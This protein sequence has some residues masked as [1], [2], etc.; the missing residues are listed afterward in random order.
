MAE[1]TAVKRAEEPAKQVQF[2]SLFEQLDD[3]FKALARRAYEIFER[4]GCNLGRDLD[5]WFQAEK[6]LLHPVPVNITEL[7]E[8]LDVQAEVPG[9]SEKEME[10][11]VEPRRL[12]ITGKRESKKEAKTGKV[13]HAECCSDQMLRI[14]ELPAEVEAERTTATLKNGILEIKLPKVSKPPTRRIHPKVA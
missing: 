3:T 7:D 5:N 12:T 8:S 10:I 14:V 13:V 2:I 9:F 1:G 6:E 11:S 4:N